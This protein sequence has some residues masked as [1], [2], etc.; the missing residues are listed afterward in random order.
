LNQ[1][2]EEEN[3]VQP[4]KVEHPAEQLNAMEQNGVQQNTD[5]DTDQEN[6]WQQYKKNAKKI[7][8]RTGWALFFF[9]LA[10]LAF[11]IIVSILINAFKPSIEDTDWYTLTLTAVTMIGV[12]LP[13]FSLFARRIPD[14]P[15][16]EVVRLT[17]S[18]FIMIFFICIAAM[19][20]ASMA[21]S[22]ITLFIAFLK[23]DME[24]YNPVEDAILNSN[25]A[26]SV[27][28]VGFIAPV[29]EEFIFRKLLLDKL[30]RFGDMPAILM[31]G[32]A[33]GLFHMNLSQLF[34]AAV[35]G[36]IFAYVTIRTNTIRYS[37]LLH[38]MVNTI[39]T[40]IITPV[41]LSKNV[42]GSMYIVQ[43][44]I[45]SV[46][47]GILFFVLNYKKI[48]LEKSASLLK[49]S[50]FLLNPGT[51][52]YILICLIWTVCVTISY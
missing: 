1:F 51:I 14:T 29:Y 15:K 36:F 39:S 32:I 28:Y 4:D 10:V 6:Y 48:K 8:S 46:A 24:L 7:I 9:A 52:A 21:G 13:V 5:R 47:V 34:Y 49:K 45:G 30:R 50:A 25:F 18:Q 44:M 26:L 37:I 20:I 27:I 17:P 40:A 16:G 23:G 43:W 19:Y 35:L 2:N 31:T 42:M 11:E 22:V 33:F 3:K 38:I 41:A 12:G